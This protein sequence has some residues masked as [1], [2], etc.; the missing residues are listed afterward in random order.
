MIDSSLN[1][2]KR[3]IKITTSNDFM[4]IH[5]DETPDDSQSNDITDAWKGRGDC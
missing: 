5:Y 1:K 4:Y 2:L 3:S